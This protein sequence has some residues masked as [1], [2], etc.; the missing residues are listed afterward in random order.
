MGRGF[1]EKAL[2]RPAFKAALGAHLGEIAFRTSRDRPK[3]GV[4]G[5]RSEWF[6]PAG[7][8]LIAHTTTT[9]DTETGEVLET[10]HGGR[11]VRKSRRRESP[12][13]KEQRTLF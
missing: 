6:D 5:I 3:A 10:T 2:T 1:G 12:P 8:K 7:G 4:L 13:E 9:I 11:A